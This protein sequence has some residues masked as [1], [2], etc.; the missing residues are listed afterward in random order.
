MFRQNNCVA[1]CA[2]PR[3]YLQPE[4]VVV[5]F[6]VK[7]DTSVVAGGE[8]AGGLDVA[9]G[10]G[11]PLACCPWAVP[12]NDAADFAGREFDE[13][14]HVISKR[15]GHGRQMKES[16][17]RFALCGGGLG[18]KRTGTA[19]GNKKPAGQKL[20]GMKKPPGGGFVG[21]LSST[22]RFSRMVISVFIFFDF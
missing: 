10:K 5:R 4:K 18:K 8:V 3:P 2:K 1:A 12:A 20:A 15:K 17:R 14:F 19:K 22:V 16:A 9:R 6:F 11:F 7:R 13:S 21:L